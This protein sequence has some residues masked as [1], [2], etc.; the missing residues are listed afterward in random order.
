M[1]NN[2][3]PLEVAWFIIGLVIFVLALWNFADAFADWIWARNKSVDTPIKRVARL[4]LLRS[5]GWIACAVLDV[6][7]GCVAIIL[8]SPQP[9]TLDSATVALLHLSTVGALILTELVI[10]GMIL[11]E[12]TERRHWRRSTFKENHGG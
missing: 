5:I 1:I 8:P 7:I 11:L 2:A 6:W 12:A 3:T 10:A 9:V 4:G